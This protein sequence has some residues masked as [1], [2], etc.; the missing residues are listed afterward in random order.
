M[1]GLG[2]SDEFNYIPREGSDELR[3]VL[4]TTWLNLA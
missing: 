4:S 1:I 2:T 3:A